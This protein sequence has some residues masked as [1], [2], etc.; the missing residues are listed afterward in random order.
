MC[1]LN[2]NIGHCLLLIV[3]DLLGHIVDMTMLTDLTLIFSDGQSAELPSWESG[4]I[5]TPRGLAK[6]QKLELKSIQLKM[7][8][9]WLNRM[10]V[11]KHVLGGGLFGGKNPLVTTRVVTSGFHHHW[12]VLCL[13]CLSLSTIDQSVHFRFTVICALAEN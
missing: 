1:V 5:V 3:Q 8:P 2:A 12:A 4:D 9:P 10:Q 13:A 11:R 6:L 7:L